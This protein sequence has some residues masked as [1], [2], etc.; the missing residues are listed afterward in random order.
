METKPLLYGII[1]FILGGLVVSIAATSFNQQ[2]GQKT[3]ELSMS[4]MS[5][6]LKDKTGDEFD[7][8]FISNMIAHHEGAIEMAQLSGERAK[9]EEVKQLSKDIIA[10]QE[11]EIKKMGLWRNQW[12]YGDSKQMNHSAH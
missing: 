7:E 12:G 5:E 3:R 9:H 4:Q 1:G 8:L 11:Q 2:S 6:S 10:A